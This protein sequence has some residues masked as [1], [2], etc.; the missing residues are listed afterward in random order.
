VELEGALPV[1]L[2]DFIFGGGLPNPKNLVVAALFT[3]EIC[4]PSL[5][6]AARSRVAGRAQT[7]S[8]V[9]ARIASVNAGA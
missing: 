5:A 2:A 7:A 1:V 6:G 8:E 9:K 3:H 4:S